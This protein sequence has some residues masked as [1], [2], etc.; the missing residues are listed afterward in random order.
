MR[1]RMHWGEK[2]LEICRCGRIGYWLP[3]DRSERKR[4]ENRN[5]YGQHSPRRWENRIHRHRTD[6]LRGRQPMLNDLRGFLNLL[7]EKKDLVHIGR[8]TSTNFEV[9]AGI[10]KTSTIEG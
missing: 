8:P 2:G 4:N 6:R 7:E 3:L 5:S 9:A 10:R 1:W